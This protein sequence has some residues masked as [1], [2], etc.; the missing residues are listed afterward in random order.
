MA[1]GAGVWGVWGAGGFL[2][3]GGLGVRWFWAVAWI[4]GWVRGSHARP[5]THTHFAPRRA[6]ARAASRRSCA[7]RPRATAPPGPPAR[8]IPPP[9]SQNPPKVYGRAVRIAASLG[10]FIAKAGR[11]VALGSAERN[12]PARAAELQNLL[13]GLG[14]SFVKIGQALSARPDLLPQT[15]LETLADLQASEG[16]R[17]RAGRAGLR[18]ALGFRW[19]GL[20]GL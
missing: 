9:S 13:S 14:P 5:R 20:F 2:G 10:G 12:A 7:G 17:G 1:A 3:A 4:W 19:R 8:P 11:D 18:A 16:E 15:Y 6:G